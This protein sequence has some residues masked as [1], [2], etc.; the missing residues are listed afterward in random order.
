MIV[1]HSLTQDEI[2]QI[3]DLMLAQ[4]NKQLTPQGM[5]LEVDDG[6]EGCAGDRRLRPELR[7]PAA[8]PRDPA[9]DRGPALRSRCSWAA[10]SDGDTIEGY[11]D[12]GKLAF[13]KALDLPTGP[14][15]PETREP[16]AV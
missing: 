10:S 7:R 15:E 12:E 11:V 14:A 3:V 5:K 1:F 9:A 16:V 13:R 4:V 6:R 2:H 8:A